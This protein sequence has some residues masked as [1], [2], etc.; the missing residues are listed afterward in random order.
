MARERTAAL[1]AARRSLALLTLG[2]SLPCFAGFS[3]PLDNNNFKWPQPRVVINAVLGF[4]GESKDELQSDPDEREEESPRDRMMKLLQAANVSKGIIDGA[5]PS[6]PADLTSS[7][8]KRRSTPSTEPSLLSGHSAEAKVEGR[9]VHGASQTSMTATPAVSASEC[10]L[11]SSGGAAVCS[12]DSSEGACDDPSASGAIGNLDSYLDSLGGEDGYDEDDCRGDGSMPTQGREALDD[13]V[14]S[15]EPSR[16]R[17]DR[18]GTW[19]GDKH[20]VISGNAGIKPE[21]EILHEGFLRKKGG[22]TSFGGRRNWKKRYF[23]LSEKKLSY[24]KTD[25]WEWEQPLGVI[26]LATSEL[27]RHIRN[28]CAV[29]LA[30]PGRVYRKRGKTES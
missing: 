27:T 11:A 19:V 13:M 8:D 17:I 18:H 4:Y 16:Q 15:M 1:H 26:W 30:S 9:A 12:A 7:L 24:Y 29:D 25:K 2:T 22:G 23:V 6:T 3:E 20:A 10:A 21:V 5:G 14:A 28:K